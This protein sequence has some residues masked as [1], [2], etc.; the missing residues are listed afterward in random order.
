ALVDRMLHVPGRDKL[1]FFYIYHALRKRSSDDQVSLT[2]KKRRNL[3]DVRNLSHNGHVGRFVN[4]RENRNMY[5]VFH[6]PEDAQAFVQSRPAKT[7]QRCAVRFV[8]R[9]L[10][11]KRNIE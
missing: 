3:Q 10:E 1:A 9:R 11:D 5:F 4:V 6:F 2:T 7:L 8:V